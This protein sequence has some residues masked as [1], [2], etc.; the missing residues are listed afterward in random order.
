MKGGS[1]RISL[2]KLQRMNREAFVALF[3]GVFENSSWVAERAW[4][5]GLFE[6]V[7]ALH[8]AM[9]K[10]VQSAGRDRQLEL[11]RSH[12]D[13]AGKA[14]VSGH[15]TDESTREQAGAGLDQL[16]LGEY[17]EFQVLNETYKNKFGFP[18]IVAVKGLT[19]GE[20]LGA[21]NERLNHSLES[22]LN[23][24]LS[25]VAKIAR[26]RLADLIDN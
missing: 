20:I 11:L 25:E 13:L 22:E 6:S 21:F 16:T 7:E 24:C 9:V 2:S 14:A 5:E 23:M 10:A 4:R 26:L 12:P 17:R 18:F 8:G 19:K 3:G 1:K 15:L